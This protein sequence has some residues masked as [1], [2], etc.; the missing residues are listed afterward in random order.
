MQGKRYLLVAGISFVAAGAVGIGCLGFGDLEGGSCSVDCTDGAA[1]TGNAADA[2]TDAPYYPPPDAGFYVVVTPSHL[3][4]DPGDMYPVNI[5]VVRANNFDDPISFQTTPANPA[6]ITA[7]TPANSGNG[8]T[9]SMFTVSF[10][11]N[12]ALGDTSLT[13]SS[14]NPAGTFVQNTMIGIRVGSEIDMSDGGFF[15]PAY[16]TGL[17]VKAWGAGGGGGAA[18]STFA[19]GAGGGGGF[20]AN[21]M[22][23]VNA[24]DAGEMLL[25]DIGTGGAAGVT[26][27]F[28]GGGGGF[29]DL[30][31][32]S[33]TVLLLA[34]GGGGG[35][36]ASSGDGINGVAGGAGGGATGQSFVSSDNACGSGGTQTAGGAGGGPGLLG[37][38]GGSMQGGAG[39]EVAGTTDG[40]APGG[41]AGGAGAPAKNVGGGG[42]G[43]G[44]WFGGGGGGSATVVGGTHGGGGGGGSSYQAIATTTTTGSGVT[45]AN[46]TDLDYHNGVGVGGATG[47]SGG[48][49]LVVVRLLKP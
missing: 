45:P 24:G 22:I 31:T 25:A 28:G 11:S 46:N 39:G 4:G 36:A 18:E 15:I 30:R 1:D 44:G 42:G 37:K 27:L 5:T 34:G 41:G 21:T 14:S 13:L 23:P 6:Q 12:A 10:A 20:A 2:S 43:G 16:A 38:Q 33:G 9:S 19:G 8:G 35:G 7:Q 3:T 47:V 40:G 29:T 26:Q 17:S 32:A 48:P 49:G